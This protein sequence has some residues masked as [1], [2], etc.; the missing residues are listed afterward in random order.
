MYRREIT[1]QG[2]L[3]LPFGVELLTDN[4]WVQFAAIMPWE[5]IDNLYQAN[6]EE[7]RGQVAKTSRLA[8]GAL[9]IQM[10]LGITD[11][12]TVNQIRENPSMQ[13]F[14]GF[15]A[16]TTVQ[17]FDSSLMVQFRKRITA[18]M[19]K[20]ITEAAFAAEAR[21]SIDDEDGDIG[22]GGSAQ[23]DD[24]TDAVADE[25]S[26][27]KGTMLLD[28]T[29]FPSDI[30]YPTDVGLLNHARE[31]TERIIDELHKQI[32]QPGVDKPRTYREVARKDFLRF[33]KKRKYGMD[34]IKAKLDDTTF[35]AISIG[36]FVKNAEKLRKL[37]VLA[38]IKEAVHRQMKRF[39][40]AGSPAVVPANSTEQLLRL[41]I[42]AGQVITASAGF[43]YP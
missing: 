30:K 3:E 29:C 6:F 39:R 7:L 42:R 8:F 32:K 2:R 18:D 17:P 4:R 41:A 16:F 20:E 15:D 23:G 37:R 10:R 38:E 14:C 24:G 33:T 5:K 43:G 36:N 21:K 40:N 11:E 25:F 26:K 35:T 31:L 22:N 19:M 28:A 1:G 13:F 12:E 9:F 34:L 27:N